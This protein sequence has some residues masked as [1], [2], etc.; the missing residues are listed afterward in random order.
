MDRSRDLDDEVYECHCKLDLDEFAP[1]RFKDKKLP[2]PYKVSIERN[3]ERVL[4][5][6]RNWREDDEEC[7]A[8]QYFADFSNAGIRHPL[9]WPAASARQCDEGLTVFWRAPPNSPTRY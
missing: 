4:E 1:K 8:K 9:H 6:R 3:T 7:M 2:L 5:V